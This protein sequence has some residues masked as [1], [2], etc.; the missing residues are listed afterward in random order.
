MEYEKKLSHPNTV[1]MPGHRPL[2]IAGNWVLTLLLTTRPSLLLPPSLSHSFITPEWQQSLAHSGSS[3]NIDM[4][5]NALSCPRSLKQWELPII[6][7]NNWR[8]S[9]HN[10]GPGLGCD[11]LGNTRGACHCGSFLTT[12]RELRFEWPLSHKTLSSTLLV[13]L[14]MFKYFIENI[15]PWNTR[16]LS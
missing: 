6:T 13:V 7:V 2:E 4:L 5:T 3:V 11:W 15:F 8:N 12:W 10:T 1:L 14:T 16:L 9:A